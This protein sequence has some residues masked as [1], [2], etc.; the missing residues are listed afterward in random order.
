MDPVIIAL[1][2]FAFLMICI[3]LGVHV[4]VAL[5]ASS[6]LGT[7]WITGDLHIAM[8]LLGRTSY[9]A[10]MV[11]IFGVAPLFIMMGLL[12]NLSGSSKE[13]Y[14]AAN[15]VFSRIRGGLGIATVIANA[16]FASITGISVASAAVFSKIAIPQMRRIGYDR[17]FSLGTVAGSSVLGML[18]PPS[19]LLILYGIMA[20][21]AI[22][23]LFIAGILPGWF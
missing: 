1:I 23:K 20:E 13:L 6:L 4:G 2:T 11:Y 19:M 8:K 3:L 17:R 10:I 12:A 21:E 9:S 5:A 15:V 14:D 7:W 16:V 18:I 22:G